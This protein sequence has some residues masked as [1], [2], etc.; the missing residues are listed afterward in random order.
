M[1]FHGAT[2]WV[3]DCNGFS[4]Y[5]LYFMFTRQTGWTVRINIIGFS[6]QS[7][8]VKLRSRTARV[9]WAQ[10]SGWQELSLSRHP[11]NKQ[12]KVFLHILREIFKRVEVPW[13][14]SPNRTLRC[15]GANF[16]VQSLCMRPVA[17]CDSVSIRALQSFQTG[18]PFRKA[19]GRVYS[20]SAPRVL[21][22]CM[23]EDFDVLWR[24]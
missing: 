14:I 4:V 1:E 24:Q 7:R 21:G 19:L 15:L 18:A 2:K 13:E 9:C 11:L 5:E 20:P 6:Q 23:L 3:P 12:C 16:P 22:P 10:D 17:S 8:P